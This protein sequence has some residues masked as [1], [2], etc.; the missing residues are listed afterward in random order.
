MR[1]QTVNGQYRQ[2][3]PSS[4]GCADSSLGEGAFGKE[5]KLYRTAKGPISEGAVCEADWGSLP[6]GAFC[7]FQQNRPQRKCFFFL[8]R[9]R[10]INDTEKM[11]G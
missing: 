7:A 2:T 6:A 1:G 4:V 3:R 9:G 10:M 8:K 5:E 11:S